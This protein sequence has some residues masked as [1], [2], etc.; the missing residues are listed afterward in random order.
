MLFSTRVLS[1]RSWMNAVELTLEFI[2][3]IFVTNI[4]WLINKSVLTINLLPLSARLLLFQ[5]NL[6]EYY[7]GFLI[8]L[9]K[10]KC[11]GLVLQLSD[12]KP[13]PAPM[14]DESSSSSK[15]NVVAKAKSDTPSQWQQQVKVLKQM[16]ALDQP[17]P[18]R[19][20]RHIILWVTPCNFSE[21][22]FQY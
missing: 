14:S 10:K 7:L 21:R 17:N 1:Y 20:L 15:E 16:M 22:I 9:K 5:T 18:V 19:L 6:I 8:D 13:E 12:R 2:I 3:F 4:L 11:V